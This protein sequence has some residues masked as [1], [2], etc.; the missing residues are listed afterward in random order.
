MRCRLLLL[1]ITV[2]VSRS[3]CL[4]RGSTRLHCAKMTEKIKVLLRLNT[5]GGPWN[6]VLDGSPDL[7]TETGHV[8]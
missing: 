3:A 5:L 8:T 1:M 7:P 2:S 6:T 4:S